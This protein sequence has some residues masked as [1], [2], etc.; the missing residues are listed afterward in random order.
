MSFGCVDN[1][2]ARNE[3]CRLWEAVNQASARTYAML[4]SP[5]TG[6]QPDD[7]NSQEQYA[8]FY[9]AAMVEA[10]DADRLFEDDEADLFQREPYLVALHTRDDAFA[11][12]LI[13]IHTRPES[14]VA[15][16]AALHDVVEWARGAYADDTQFIVLGDLN[17][18][19][20]YASP[21]ALDAL[22]LRGPEYFWVVPD[23]SDSNVS[24]NSQCAY[25]RIVTTS[26][27]QSRFTGRWGVDAWFTDVGVSDHWPVWGQRLPS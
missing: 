16:I 1:R 12:V 4:L 17:A 3:G 20:D 7:Q 11:F 2:N 25:D 9:D 14:A 13:D 21:R 5:R 19:C 6:R 22:A 27:V 18:G 23:D 10:G 8:V 24:P 26:N 15:E